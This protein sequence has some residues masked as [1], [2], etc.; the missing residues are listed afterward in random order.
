VLSAPADECPLTLTSSVVDY[1]AGQSAGRCGPCFNGLP[2]L[3][4]AFDTFVAGGPLAPVEKI[5]GLVPGRGAC[6]HPDGTARLVRSALAAFPEE[7]ERHAAGGC[8]ARDRRPLE[9]VVRR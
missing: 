7:V 5:V 9:A 8:H 2:A 1:L 4:T 6:A 3:A